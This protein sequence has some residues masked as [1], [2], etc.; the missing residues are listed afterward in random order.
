MRPRLPAMSIQET[1]L[2]G[3]RR[4]IT[5]Q[6]RP[7]VHLTGPTVRFRGPPPTRISPTIPT[8]PRFGVILLKKLHAQSLLQMTH[9][10]SRCHRQYLTLGTGAFHHTRCLRGYSDSEVFRKTCNRV[11]T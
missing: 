8:R 11:S 4:R 1:I 9:P 6:L 10:P 7:P 2:S 5:P 3:M